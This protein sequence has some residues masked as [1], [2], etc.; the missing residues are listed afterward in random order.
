[1]PGRRSF[2]SSQI[3]FKRNSKEKGKRNK[4][5]GRLGK[6]NK[7]EGRLG[8][9][10]KEEGRLGKRNKEEGRLGTSDARRMDEICSLSFVIDLFC[11]ALPT[12]QFSVKTK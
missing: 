11:G 7:E 5:E 8:K 3:I 12:F 6:R 2:S 1:M 4:E 10:N 9:R